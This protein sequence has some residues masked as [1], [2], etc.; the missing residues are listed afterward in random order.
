MFFVYDVIIYRE[1]SKESIQK[2]LKKVTMFVK[3][4]VNI[5]NLSFYI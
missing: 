5:K 3:E 1:N 4:N 2:L